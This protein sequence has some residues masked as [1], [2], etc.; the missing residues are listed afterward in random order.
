MHNWNAGKEAGTAETIFNKMD[1]VLQTNG[2]FWSNCVGTCVDNT[3]KYG[4]KKLN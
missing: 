3:S 4:N 1:E 2:V